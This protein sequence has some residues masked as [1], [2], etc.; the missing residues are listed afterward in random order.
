MSIWVSGGL[1]ILLD[2]LVPPVIRVVVEYETLKC[3]RDFLLTTSQ[4]GAEEHCQIGA[5]VFANERILDWL[6]GVLRKKK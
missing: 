1:E 2:N 4:D 6:E 3:P 5:M